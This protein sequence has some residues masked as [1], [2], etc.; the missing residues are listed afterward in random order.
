MVYRILLILAALGLVLAASST[1]TET[2][3][4][5]TST[6][7]SVLASD[8]SAV[9]EC[10]IKCIWTSG[11]K[12]GCAGTGLECMCSHSDAF[13][14]HFQ[15]CLGND[16]TIKIFKSLWDVRQQICDAVKSSSNSAALASAS[17]V[18]ASDMDNGA[19]RLTR[20]GILGATTWAALAIWKFGISTFGHEAPNF[21]KS[22]IPGMSVII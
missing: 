16:C 22:E 6:D 17:A 15:Q 10:G 4:A 21:A 11:M 14:D 8:L 19:E 18:I 7:P 3:S 1:T 12:I 13:A 5:T 2:T 20:A 9:P